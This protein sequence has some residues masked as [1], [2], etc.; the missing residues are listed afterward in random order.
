MGCFVVFAIV[1]YITAAIIAIVVLSGIGWIGWIMLILLTLFLLSRVVIKKGY[2]QRIWKDHTALQSRESMVYNLSYIDNIMTE[3]TEWGCRVLV[4]IPTALFITWL[5]TLSKSFRFLSWIGII[6]LIVLFV[7][8]GQRIYRIT[9]WNKK[10]EIVEFGQEYGVKEAVSKYDV[11]E[12]EI[13]EW[14]KLF[15][16]EENR[17]KR[18]ETIRKE[19]NIRRATVEYG[20]LYGIKA[21]SDKYG[22]SVEDICKWTIEAV[23]AEATEAR[24]KQEEEE[25]WYIQEQLKREIKQEESTR[26]LL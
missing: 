25:A 10:K 14:T 16:E 18:D 13:Q 20:K 3:F 6:G 5:G 8:L 12:I 1:S 17:L 21:A 22:R 26:R 4:I 2:T 23:E 15:E 19:V 11:S 24:R 9:S 7:I